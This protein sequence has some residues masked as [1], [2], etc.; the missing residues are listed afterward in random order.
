MLKPPGKSRA[1]GGGAE[2]ALPSPGKS[3]RHLPLVAIRFDR[4]AV[5]AW[6]MFASCSGSEGAAPRLQTAR[7]GVGKETSAI[8]KVGRAVGLGRGRDVPQRVGV[9]QDGMF[10]GS[11]EIIPVAIDRFQEIGGG[12]YCS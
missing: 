10:S 9:D 5:E 4:S 1:G 6:Q 8:K 11:D 3:P 7:I 2:D 12:D